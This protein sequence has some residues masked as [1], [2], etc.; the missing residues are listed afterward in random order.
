MRSV[1]GHISPPYAFEP[2]VLTAMG[3]AYDRAL[4]SFSVPPNRSFREA[5]AG[6]IIRLAQR[7]T[8][9]PGKLCEEILLAYG[10]SPMLATRKARSLG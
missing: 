7:G 6:E 3:D 4:S 1:S 10:F 9:D 5:I 8:S 2:P